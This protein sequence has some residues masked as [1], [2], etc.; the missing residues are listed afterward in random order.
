MDIHLLNTDKSHGALRAEVEW[1]RR[2]VAVT[3]GAEQYESKLRS[4]EVEDWVLVWVNEIGVVAAGQPVDD[5]VQRVTGAEVVNPAEPWEFHR[6]MRWRLDL[7]DSPIRYAEFLELTGVRPTGAGKRILDPARKAAVLSRLAELGDRCTADPIEYAD[8]A[9]SMLA[10]GAVTR[11]VGNA[12]PKRVEGTVNVFYRSPWVR[13]WTIQRAAC[14]CELCETS[15]PFLKDSGTPY[16]ELHHVVP[17]AEGGGDT[18]ENTA[19][20]C[21]NCHRELHH[22]R[23]RSS[24]REVLRSIV[25]QKEAQYR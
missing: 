9:D 19:A 16:L 6:R 5:V 14:S 18:P 22:G 15:A 2:G 10:S 21:P 8:A 4:I 11:P 7:R 12:A 24:K 25:L 3:S 20:L 17:M 13:A 23:E 1:L